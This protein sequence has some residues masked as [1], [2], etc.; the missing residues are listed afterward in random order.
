MHESWRVWIKY[1]TKTERRQRGDPR[2]IVLRLCQ[3]GIASA[4]R[5]AVPFNCRSP[6]RRVAS[7]VL[8]DVCNSKLWI[9]GR[10]VR[11]G[12]LAD[13]DPSFADLTLVVRRVKLQ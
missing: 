5:F 4:C 10:R 7:Y 12:L 13:G 11:F 8:N 6:A 3:C 9:L 1:V 2:T